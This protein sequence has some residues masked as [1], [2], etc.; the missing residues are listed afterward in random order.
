LHVAS[1]IKRGP[2]WDEFKEF[3]KLVVEAM[4]RDAPDRFVTI[5]TKSRRR[6]KIF[7]DYLRNGRNATFIAPYSPRARD[8]ATVATPI[9]WEELAEGVDPKQFTT[10]TVPRRLAQLSEDPW[11]D[12]A[13]SAR[14]ITAAARRAVK[15]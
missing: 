15:P 14:A 13:K 5:M 11:A 4:E 12:L 6:G 8:N 2:S 7:L 1:P 10:A 9:T 3:T